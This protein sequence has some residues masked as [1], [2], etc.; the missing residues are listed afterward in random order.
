[1]VG[2]DIREGV[3]HMD[4]VPDAPGTL[5]GVAL[6]ADVGRSGE[7]DRGLDP[8]ELDMGGGRMAIEQAGLHA[9]SFDLERGIEEVECIVAEVDLPADQFLDNRTEGAP[10]VAAFAEEGDAV[11]ADCRAGGMLSAQQAVEERL[12][13]EQG[14]AGQRDDGAD[15]RAAGA[16]VEIGES[17]GRQERGHDQAAPFQMWCNMSDAH[18]RVTIRGLLRMRSG[19]NPWSRIR[20][21]APAVPMPCS[22]REEPMPP[23][24]R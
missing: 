16:G 13:R 4:Q 19:A 7:H 24:W 11:V 22:A 20:S 17:E 6:G 5:D 15:Q 21:M 18:S 12:G 1:M 10:V 8:G 14:R 9:G 3:E 23:A 2:G